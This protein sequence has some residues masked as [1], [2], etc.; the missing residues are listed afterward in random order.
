MNSPKCTLD[1]HSVA[2]FYTVLSP[3]SEGQVLSL[4]GLLSPE[5]LDRA[6]RFVF[7]RDRQLFMV[8]HAL[9]RFGLSAVAGARRWT[10]TADSFGKPQLDPPCGDPPLCFNLSHTNGLAACAIAFGHPVGIDVEEINPRLDFH[11]IAKKALSVEEQCLIASRRSSE[12]S[13]LFFRFWTL[14]EAMVKGLG[15]G[16]TLALQDFAFA[17]D[18][19]SLSIAPHLEEDPAAWQMYESTPTPCHRLALAVKRPPQ[20]ILPVISQPVAV[21]DLLNASQARSV[22]LPGAHG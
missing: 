10:F 4:H 20:T 13:A 18:P 22:T 9:L 19:L 12:Q 7:A 15:Y 21:A 1:A 3:L 14:K 16:L 8:A 17:L 5:E 2:V 6:S 11:A